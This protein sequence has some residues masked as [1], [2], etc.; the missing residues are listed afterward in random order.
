MVLVEDV[1]GKTVI[2]IDDMADTCKTILH[3]VEEL[4]KKGAKDVYAIVTHGILSDSAIEDVHRSHLKA[5]VVTN[6]IPQAEHLS[7]SHKIKVIDVSGI[8]AD[9]IIKSNGP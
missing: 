7:R 1:T 3:A 2:I 9:A 5:L 6:T 8:F 4:Q